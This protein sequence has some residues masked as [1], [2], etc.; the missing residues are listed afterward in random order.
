MSSERKAKGLLVAVVIWCIILVAL[1][2]SYKFVIQP[3]LGKREVPGSSKGQYDHIVEIAHDSFSGYCILRSPAVLNQLKGERIKLAFKDDQ[4][5]YEGRMKALKSG[6]VQ[7]AV[8]TVDSFL[9][10]GAKLGEFPASIVLV[11]DETQGADAVLAFKESVP[12]IRALDNPDVRFVMTPSSPS[13]FLARTVIA[14]F[15]LPSLPEKWWRE[16]DGSGDVYKQFRAARKSDKRAYVMWEPYVSKALEEPGAHVLIDSSKLKGYIV[17][18]LVVERGFLTSQPEVVQA[19]V[20]AYLRAAYSYR[21]QDGGIV[22]LVVADADEYGGGGLKKAEAEKVVAGIQW[23]NTQE[24]Y[25]RFGLLPAGDAQGV[26]HIEDIIANITDV[27]VK[28][29]AIEEDPLAGRANSIYYDRVLANLKA[30]DF[31]PAK[32][33]SVIAGVGPGQADLA[34]VRGAAALPALDDN[35]WGRLVPAG[36]LRI[37][38][39][40]FAR[41]TARINIQSQRELGDLAKRLRSSLTSYYVMVTGHARNEGDLDANIRLANERAEVVAKAMTDLGVQSSRVRAVA[42]EPSSSNGRAQSVSFVVG[43]PPY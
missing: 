11:I 41:G 7:M 33:L 32:K 19:I 38:P 43:Q 17:D 9:V 27:L 18:V 42:A 15:S 28:T 10:S 12:D 21:S 23:Q 1:G 37:K 26:Q 29:D 8:F 34:A 5:D 31:H 16:A 14:T 4:A 30:E 2:G 22:N 3:L 24:N 40:A 20:D 35:A 25:V 36:E 6:K 39:I 13:E